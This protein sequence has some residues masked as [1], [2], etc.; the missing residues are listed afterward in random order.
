MKRD[1]NPEE[2]RSSELLEAARRLGSESPRGTL[3]AWRGSPGQVSGGV[4]RG[5]I[6][7]ATETNHSR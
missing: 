7:T 5:R 4:K 6:L 1:D 3:C 2:P